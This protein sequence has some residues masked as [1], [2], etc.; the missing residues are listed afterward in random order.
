[1]AQAENFAYSAQLLVGV[2]QLVALGIPGGHAGRKLPPVLDVQQHPRHQ[3]RDFLGP[4][5]GA[6]GAR[7]APGK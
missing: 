4:L 2:D 7:L 6:Q 1:M 5:F 3:A